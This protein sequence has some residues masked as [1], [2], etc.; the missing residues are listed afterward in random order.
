MNGDGMV[1]GDIPML[2]IETV[3]YQVIAVILNRPCGS[4][5]CR[6]RHPALPS[7]WCVPC[8]LSAVVEGVAP[9]IVAGI[10]EGKV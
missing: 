5:P 1:S 8:V 4:F 2:D 6:E 9:G 3:E 7:K 10:V